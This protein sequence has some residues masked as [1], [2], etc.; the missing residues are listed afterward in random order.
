MIEV[1][2]NAKGMNELKFNLHDGQRDALL[3]KER[4]ILMLCGAQSGKTSFAPLWLMQ[5][6]N[7]RGAGEYICASGNF[8]L[9]SKKFQP[10]LAKLFCRY[11]GYTYKDKQKMFVKN[12]KDGDI[13]IYLLSAESPD[14]WES[15]TAKAAV[16]DEAG[17]PS[18]KVEI[19]EALQRRLSINKGRCLFTTTPYNLGWLKTEIYDRCVNEVETDYRLINFTSLMNPL[20]PKDEY[21]RLKSTMPDW[22]FK[23]FYEGEFTRPAAMIYDCFDFTIRDYATNSDGSFSKFIGDKGNIVHP[24]KIPDNWNRYLGVDFGSVNSCVV[25]VAESPDN[26]GIYFVY[27]TL[28]G[29]IIKD[30]NGVGQSMI[31]DKI[32][33]YNHYYIAVGGAESEDDWRKQWTEHGVPVHKPRGKGGVDAGIDRVWTLINKEKLFVFSSCDKLLSELH[34]Y[35]RD[36]D[37]IGNTLESIADKNSYHH[38]DALRYV[39]T[40]LFYEQYEVEEKEEKKEQIVPNSEMDTRYFKQTETS[41]L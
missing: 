9:L 17:L 33:E 24:F 15:M 20:F 22:K 29:Y 6:I 3:A 27:H 10:E 40:I 5:E 1:V 26:P 11:L 39:G 18:V 37:A 32:K 28:F 4:F 38:L 12:T 23:M 21:E 31:Y 2:R 34:S 36:V 41:L 35:S 25:F 16:F 14:N 19:W 8:G 30:K 7:K 13:T